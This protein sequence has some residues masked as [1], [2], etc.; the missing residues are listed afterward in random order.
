MQGEYLPINGG[1]GIIGYDFLCPKC[2][3]TNR[4]ATNESC[5]ECDFD[6]EYKD[7]DEWYDEIM[8]AQ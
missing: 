6:Q 3:H 4:F 5:E 7:P 2:N 8:E 1:Y